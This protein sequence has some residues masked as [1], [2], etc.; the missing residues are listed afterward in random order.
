MF[1]LHTLRPQS[2]YNLHTWFPGAA[3]VVDIGIEELASPVELVGAPR[4][5]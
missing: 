3:A 4:A 5:L 1:H 2:R